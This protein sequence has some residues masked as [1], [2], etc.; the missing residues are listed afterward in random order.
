MILRA[1]QL[2][3]RPRLRWQSWIMPLALVAMIIAFSIAQPRF[4][5]LSNFEN[6]SR[7]A[8]LLAII[9]FA[10]AFPILV[11]G[12]DI[13]MGSMI[14][15][16]SVVM[17][18]VAMNDGVVAGVIAGV[19]LGGVLGSINGIVIARF[20]VSPFIATLAMLSAAR[21]FALIYTNG[22]PI[23]DL[24]D[25]FAVLAN[26]RIGPFSAPFLVAAGVFLVA[27]FVLTRTVLGRYIY[28]VGSNEQAAR[29]SGIPVRKVR[30]VSY[31]ITGLLT[32]IGGVVLTSRVASGQ[33]N[34]GAGVELDAIA[35]VLLGGI[36][37][38]G[39][40]GS[41][42]GVIFGVATLAIISN[43][44]NLANVSSYLQMIAVGGIIVLAMIVSR[45]ASVQSAKP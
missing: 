45:S 39:G 21:G 2:L 41:L 42:V 35:A 18:S 13:S 24:P 14:G 7:Q 30:F 38:G 5:T 31:T 44:L 22:S 32:G 12:L 6:V 15:A 19:L 33:P 36:A 27:Y 4:G 8:S 9:A 26:A 23:Y 1:Q 37:F 20:D 11:G 17:A 40:R 43:G 3:K 34:L 10:A 28:A 29:L 16:T 25:S